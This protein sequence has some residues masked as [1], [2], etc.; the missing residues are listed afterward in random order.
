MINKIA[1]CKESTFKVSDYLYIE[2][3][4]S[5][6]RSV[7]QI[8]D[9]KGCI[10]EVKDTEGD[11][12]ALLDEYCVANAKRLP[13][14]PIFAEDISA[15]IEGVSIKRIVFIPKMQVYKYYYEIAGTIYSSIE[16]RY[17]LDVTR[18]TMRHTFVI[19]CEQQSDEVVQDCED[20]YYSPTEAINFV[21][22]SVDN[23]NYLREASIP[24][25]LLSDVVDDFDIVR[26]CAET[27]VENWNSLMFNDLVYISSYEESTLYRV[28]NIHRDT[29]DL[30]SAG[31]D[32]E[33][34]KPITVKSP[35]IRKIP[36]TIRLPE[37]LP[38]CVKEVRY[39]PET[40]KLNFMCTC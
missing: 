30:C 35:C 10:I 39:I 22:D 18:R 17:L 26:G 5:K 1:K 16:T 8:T 2:T 31:A 20:I 6:E 37:T 12:Y 27:L 15:P 13:N 32:S 7:L 3:S 14:P 19:S 36:V 25:V 4:K 34:V 24:F 29:V 23:L 9:I 40:A 11:T 28:H 21:T 33:Y 38:A